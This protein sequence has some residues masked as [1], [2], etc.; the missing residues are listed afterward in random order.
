MKGGKG[1]NLKVS[2][3]IKVV[4]PKKEETMKNSYKGTDIVPQTN[5]FIAQPRYKE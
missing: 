5:N 1:N 2:P 4:C 3:K